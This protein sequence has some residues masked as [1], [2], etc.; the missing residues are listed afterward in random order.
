VHSCSTVLSVHLQHESTPRASV[1]STSPNTNED[2]PAGATC[3]VVI[4]PQ[5]NPVR[6]TDDNRATVSDPT[7]E[8]CAVLE[9]QLC[10]A[11]L[12]RLWRTGALMKQ[13]TSNEDT[14]EVC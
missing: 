1:S 8:E 11:S 14:I 7:R 9:A 10:D 2:T 5:D 13:F 6:A 3:A 12:Y 4:Q